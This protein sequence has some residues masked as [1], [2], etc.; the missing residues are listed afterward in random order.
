MKFKKRLKARGLCISGLCL[1]SVISFALAGTASATPVLFVPTKGF[2]YHFT[3]VGPKTSLLTVGG[4]EVKSEK[5]DVLALVLNS[6]LFDV[7]LEFLEATGPDGSECTNTSRS[8]DIL[9]NLLGHLGLADPGDVPA[10][11]L[12]V[13]SGFEFKCEALGGLVKVPVKVQKSIIGQIASPALGVPSELM[14][15]VF[16]QSKG[17]Q[18]FTT[19][20]LN[21]ETLTSQF[22]ETSVNGGAFEQSGELGEADLKALANQ[23]TFTLVAP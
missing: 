5:V 15:L 18:Q 14:R 21:N 1:M 11:L 16:N 22:E 13:P 20:L 4:S 8:N 7:H 3:G 6:T 23:G 17:V 9:V 2:P 12:L 10:V 19:F